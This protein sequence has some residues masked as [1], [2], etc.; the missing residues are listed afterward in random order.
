M[1]IDKHNSR[2][3]CI[4][5]RFNANVDHTTS[6]QW[7]YSPLH[8]YTRLYRGDLAFAY[9]GCA[10]LTAVSTVM[11]PRCRIRRC[12]FLFNVDHTYITSMIIFT[13]YIHAYIDDIWHF[14]ICATAMTQIGFTRRCQF[15]FCYHLC[16]VKCYNN[17]CLVVMR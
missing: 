12:Q 17:E 15:L 5:W 10:G 8:I 13:A 3:I 16:Y 2:L 1:L 7:S 14:H 4:V 9:I 6:H 11:A